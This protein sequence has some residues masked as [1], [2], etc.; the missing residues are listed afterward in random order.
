MDCNII[1]N[2]DTEQTALLD[3]MLNPYKYCT[4][5]RKGHNIHSTLLFISFIFHQ[6]S[7][8]TVSSSET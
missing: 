1:P 5:D 8:I 4:H 7:F 3:K 6:V 2:F